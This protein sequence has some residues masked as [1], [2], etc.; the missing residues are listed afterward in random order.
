MNL[1]ALALP[2]AA[3]SICLIIFIPSSRSGYANHWENENSFVYY[4]SES[5]IFEGEEAGVGYFYVSGDTYG[6]YL[7]DSDLQDGDEVTLIF[8]NRE[9]REEYILAEEYGIESTTR[10]DNGQIVEIR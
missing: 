7:T 10:V 4:T 8:E 6:A 1:S 9:S 2:F 5:A 3:V